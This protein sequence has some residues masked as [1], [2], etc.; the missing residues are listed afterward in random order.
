MKGNYSGCGASFNTEIWLRQVTH[1]SL[2]LIT[3]L[4]LTMVS[5]QVIADSVIGGTTG[6]V[7]PTRHAGEAAT[8]LPD[9]RW[10]L[11]GGTENGVT[12]ATLTLI[13]PVTN[14][15]THFAGSLS[16]PRQGHTS[17]LL[18]DG[19]VLIVGGVDASSSPLAQ[20][21]RLNIQT[22]Q[23]Q[24]VTD[25]TFTART[26]HTATL[27]LDGR[28]LL[29]GGLSAQ[30][31]ALS[32]AELWDSQTGTVSQMP[33]G[34]L[35]AR[36]GHTA[37]TLPTDLILIQGGK[38][39]SDQLVTRGE[40]FDPSR[41]V[42]SP[43]E[44][45][46]SS[47]LATSQS[48][49]SPPQV[50]SS[51]PAA[52]ANTVAVSSWI[53]LRFSK[54]MA[55]TSLSSNT[56]TVI[57]PT[58][59]T[60]GTVTPV[61]G[62]Q[63]VF[64]VPTRELLPDTYYNVF[65]SGATD[66]SGTQL[67]LTGYSFTTKALTVNVASTS[68]NTNSSDALKGQARPLTTPPGL[69]MANTGPEDWIPGP[70]HFSGDWR[71]KRPPSPLQDLPPLQAPL[72]V[73]ALAG[74]V[75]L[76]NGKA[77]VG[78]TLKMGEKIATTDPTGRFLLSG[79]NTGNQTLRIDGSGANKP[80]RQYGFFDDLVVIF[81]DGKTQS[82][83]YT[84]WLPHTDTQHAVSLPSPTTSEVTVTTPHIPGL[85]LHIPKGTVIRDIDGKVVTSVSIT[86]IP[87]DR[88]PFPLPTHGIPVYFTIQPGSANL[89]AIDPK[90]FQAARIIY[91]NYNG[92][93]SGSTMDFWTYDP[94]YKGWYVYGEGLV[95]ANGKQ[96]I[97]G[98]GVGIYEFTG[99]MVS[100]PSLAPAKNPTAGGGYQGLEVASS[101]K[102]EP[103]DTSTGL[104]T[105]PHTDLTVADT[106]PLTLTRTY[107]SED[108]RSRAF[109]VGTNHVYDIFMVGDT[110]PWT[111]QDLILSNGGRIHFNR[112]S[113]GTNYAT[114]VYLHNGSPFD[115]YQGATIS[116][117][118][119]A[120][121]WLLKLKDGYQMW[122]PNAQ[123]NNVPAKAAMTQIKDRVGNTI[124]LTRASNGNL[125]QVT[126][127][128]GRWISFTYD[129]SNRITQASDNMGRTVSYTYDSNGNLQ[130]VTDANG[131]VETY[132][133]DSAHHMLT[134][135]RPNGNVLLSNSYDAN[136]R[137]S[138]QTL[139]YGSTVAG[140]YQFAYTLSGS[141]VTQT[142]I[143]DPRGN[144]ERLAFNGAGYVT[145]NTYGLGLPEQQSYSLQRDATTNQVTSVTDAM[146]RVAG[147]THDG[148]GNL[149]SVTRLQGTSQAVTDSYT[150]DPTFN[151][152]T[153]HT[154]GLSHTTNYSYDSLGR[155]TQIIDT[156][157]NAVKFTSDDQGRVTQITDPIGATTAISYVLGDVA[158]VNDPLG[159]T[160]NYYT[161][162]VGR[163]LAI[164]DAV[165]RR[166]LMDYDPLDRKTKV[167]DPLGNITSFAYDTNSNLLSVTDAK[168]GVHAYSYDARDR[169]VSYTDPLNATQSYGLDGL[170]NVT[171]WTARNGVI[172]T[173]TYDALNRRTQSAFGQT[174]I[175]SGPSL[176]APD[177]TVGY[178]FDGGNRLTQIVDTQ[179]GTIT[180]GYDNLDHLLSETTP[181]GT[182]SYAYDAADRRTSMTVTGQP[183]VNYTYD[184]GNRLTNLGNGSQNTAFTYDADNR[185]ATLTLPNGVT[186]SYGYDFAGQLVNLNYTKGGSSLG[187]LSYGY[188]NAGQRVQLGGSLARTT[189]PSVVSTTSYNAANQL[190]A[191][192][193][194]TLL[195]DANGNMTSDGSNTYTWDSRQRLS[196]LTGTVSGSFSYDAANRRSQKTIAGQTTGYVFDGI[197]L[198][199]E[200][201]GAVTP[202]VQA[203]LLTGGVDEVFSRTETSGST[204]SYLAD[205]L[206]STQALSDSS[207]AFTTQYTY[208]PYG[209]T[210]SSGSASANSQQYTGRENDGTGVYYYRARYFLPG[211]GRFLSGDPTGLAGGINPYAYVAGNPISN[212]DPQGEFLVGLVGAGVGA[213]VGA[214][215]NLLTQ[216]VQNGGNWSC[217]SKENVF[218]SAV[219]GGA[220][221]FLLTTS[222]GGS[223]LGVAGV[224]ATTNL[225][226]YG[227]T[228]APHDYSAVGASASAISGAVGG[229]IAG[230]SPNPYMFIS[231]SPA[232]NDLGLVSKMVGGKTLGMNVLGGAVGSF[233]YTKDTPRK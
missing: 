67:P 216:V 219:T 53:S 80:G 204:Y 102:G 197:N 201:T 33:T 148:V 168:N 186:V 111:Y 189:L 76:M 32:S 7:A 138:Q 218:W 222:L 82:L 39:Q 220:A 139:G 212:T 105:Y 90:S 177:A 96:V 30:H 209:Q 46:Q 114:A 200:L 1:C 99:A 188:D 84:I 83:Q 40:L 22:Q 70:E 143:T 92:R 121:P 23:S 160:T 24:P 173:Y 5:S 206:G 172:A 54:P 181:Q 116:W 43:Q 110:N 190:T 10:L 229:V 47:L 6:S 66:E 25:A 224:G 158:S 231:P 213:A 95:S 71:A 227:L 215:T 21:E 128:N 118:G 170:D 183:A 115:R 159:R 223:M 217:V 192:G 198:V 146:G 169:R 59:Q 68:T 97:P 147:Y 63:A 232:L 195:Y 228:T 175:G 81:Q 35:S 164:S 145:T 85:E 119:G 199:Q 93:P 166:T 122:F 12:L 184:A 107:L 77:A 56:V 94:V 38:D 180:R 69:D 124:S 26:Q 205:A 134:I 167:T 44:E 149:T 15:D 65:V 211:F 179:G 13:D 126:S 208:D 75:L 41:Q 49:Q 20:A 36:Y 135:T 196:T 142:D 171:Q 136:G 42:F 154:D 60:A 11:S 86:P 28:V 55:V 182:V 131:G 98:D 157:G 140:T 89:Q 152:L 100:L 176:T 19:T 112:I 127:P 3:W 193:G 109:G 91:P 16:M 144:I 161:D 132:T 233:D 191:W 50:Q 8:L 130:T 108:T 72:G 52:N 151:Q 61:E 129:S 103:V 185:R 221:G 207:G 58:G 137:V 73:T 202:T 4:V 87:V 2:L 163:V 155:L 194:A 18:P 64:F 165:G 120:S 133:Y 214:V 156:L 51:L 106:L 117:V 101:D 225:L 104:F 74:Q 226:N 178:T 78:V 14:T 230:K 123:D 79:I 150:Y 153:S 187:N 29:A 45:N 9:G 37:Q 210:S 17:T 62:G 34:L 31:E 203:N 125:Q 174:L 141:Q 88:T 48:L 113:S 27:L 162:S 57:G